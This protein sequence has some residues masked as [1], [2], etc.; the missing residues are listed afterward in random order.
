MN[1]YQAGKRNITILTIGFVFFLSCNQKQDQFVVVQNEIDFLERL[2]EAS[3]QASAEEFVLPAFDVIGAVP[4]W[5]IFEH[6]HSVITYNNIYVGKEG[7]IDFSIGIREGAWGHPGDGVKFAIRVVPAEGEEIT[8]QKYINPKKNEEEQKWFDER[9]PLSNIED[10]YVTVIFETLPG[11]SSESKNRDSDWAVWGN[12]KLLSSGKQ[13][14]HQFTSSTNVILITIDTLRADYLGCY[15]NEWIETP[16]IDSLAQGGALFENAYS[17]SST[18]SPSHVSIFTSLYPYAHGVIGNDYY[19]ADRLPR[20]TQNLKELNYQTGAA[21]SVIHLKKNTS[22]LGKWFDLYEEPKGDRKGLPSL[23]RAG[24]TTTSAAI[25][26]LEKFHNAP[27]FLWIHYYDPHAPYIAEGEFHR[28]YYGD[29]PTS[30]NHTSMKQAIYKRDWLKQNQFWVAGIQDSEYFK[31]EYGA[32][33]AFV[34]HQI[35]RLLRA[36]ERLQLAENTLIVLTADHGENLGDHGIYYD[37]WFLYNSD[38]HVPLIFYY[39]KDIP[40]GL[41]ISTDA[42][43]IDIAPTILDLIGDADNYFAQEFYEGRSLRT[44]WESPEEWEPRILSADALLFL[45]ISAWNDRYKVVWEL[46]DAPYHPKK[47]L[48]KNRVWVYDRTADPGENNPVACFY[49]GDH[50][51][52]KVPWES[53]KREPPAHPN[54]ERFR[55]KLAQIRESASRKT[56]PTA[57]ELKRWFQENNTRDLLREDLLNNDDFFQQVVVLLETLRERVNPPSVLERLDEIY[58]VD[59]MRKIEMESIQIDDPNFDEQ[60][61]SLGYVQ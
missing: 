25:G 10:Q 36:L 34:D 58:D 56:V 21:V 8:Y 1:L 2:G 15:G 59:S 44:L 26:M 33:I 32:E 13:E 12:P 39:P 11:E 49:W 38:I 40:K 48:L 43:G 24:S 5:G 53:I 30:P 28:K 55:K 50:E 22:G 42:S 54:K 29:D 52:K 7:A 17:T 27:F 51:K 3:I 6:T 9:F 60:L 41:R 35:G 31:R 4:H 18:T 45:Q 57:D 19:V 47:E 37:H 20:L 23:T 46:R 61:K 16:N 14:K